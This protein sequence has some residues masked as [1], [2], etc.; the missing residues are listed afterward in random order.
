MSLPERHTPVNTAHH[1]KHPTVP[2]TITESWADFGLEDPLGPTD[3]Q[4]QSTVHRLG[5][6][7]LRGLG[8]T[9]VQPYTVSGHRGYCGS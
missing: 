8:H 4:C 3:V 7:R 6:Y 9:E 1:T 2:A 5:L